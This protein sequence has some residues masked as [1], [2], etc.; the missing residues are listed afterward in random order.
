MNLD[1]TTLAAAMIASSSITGA[2]QAFKDAGLPSK[3][4][5][6][7]AIATG[8]ALGGAAAAITSADI[9]LGIGAGFVSG[10]AA[11]ATYAY[12]SFNAKVSAQAEGATPTVIETPT[13]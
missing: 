12:V 3:F 5:R 1:S 4:A 13:S 2:V 10:I 6:L 8:T 7:A 11:A 9:S